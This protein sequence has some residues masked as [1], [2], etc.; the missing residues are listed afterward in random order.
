MLMCRNKRSTAAFDHQLRHRILNRSN[1]YDWW[2]QLELSL[3]N[4][5]AWHK[6]LNFCTQFLARKWTLRMLLDDRNEAH[7]R[8]P[9]RG[10]NDV[11]TRLGRADITRDSSA[12][13]FPMGTFMTTS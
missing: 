6:S 4:P 2:R 10:D 5:N 13:N 3:S 11:L 1:L 9:S 8:L 12:L 7:Q